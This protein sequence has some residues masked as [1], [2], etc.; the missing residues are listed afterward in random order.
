MNFVGLLGSEPEAIDAD[1]V[2]PP[3]F[4][5]RN[6]KEGLF[7]MEEYVKANKSLT[8]GKASQ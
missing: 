4:K 1:V 8:E 7:D 5:D 2:I 6:I 3:I